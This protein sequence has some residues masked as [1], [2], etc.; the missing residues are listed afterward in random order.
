ML[1]LL[2]RSFKQMMATSTMATSETHFSS[3]SYRPA[4]IR[5]K[6]KDFIDQTKQMD[7]G[8]MDIGRIF[9]I[10]RHDGAKTLF[11]TSEKPRIA[12]SGVRNSWLIW[13]RNCDLAMLAAS[14]RS[15]RFIGDRFCLLQLA[16]Q[17]HLFPLAPPMSPARWNKVD[18][19]AQRSSLGQS[20]TINSEDVVA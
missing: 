20:R 12:L 9:L 19:S 6:N 13:A 7:P 2:A 14:A 18:R 16:N 8:V 10:S 15:A 4:S 1:R 11:I 5:Q 17:K 3:S